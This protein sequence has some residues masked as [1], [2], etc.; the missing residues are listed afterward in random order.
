[1]YGGGR[2]RTGPPY[3]SG[4]IGE[5]LMR[6]I[7]ERGGAARISACLS[8]RWID[9]IEEIVFIQEAHKLGCPCLDNEVL[10]C[11]GFNLCIGE[12]VQVMLPPKKLIQ[13]GLR[14]GHRSLFGA[15]I[16]L[17][18][19][20][21]YGV[22][23][24]FWHPQKQECARTVVECLSLK[25]IADRAFGWRMRGLRLY[26]VLDGEPSSSSS[27]SASSDSSSSD[28]DD[29]QDDSAS[30]QQSSS[31]QSSSSNDGSSSNSSESSSSSSSSSDSSSSSSSNSSNSAIEEVVISASEVQQM[32]Y[33]P[34]SSNVVEFSPPWFLLCWTGSIWDKFPPQVCQM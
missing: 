12:R 19:K 28:G 5:R 33:E 21:R 22:W 23:I 13:L 8:P 7:K 6:K 32:F 10:S 11:E 34:L 14:L 27:S 20:S 30:S 17:D 31:E 24:E 18:T 26:R 2:L 9:I 15:T 4:S 1:M 25:N 3:R 16:G 29:A